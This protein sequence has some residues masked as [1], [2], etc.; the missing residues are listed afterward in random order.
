MDGAESAEMLVFE[1]DGMSEKVQTKLT[2]GIFD[3][4]AQKVAGLI[5]QWIQVMIQSL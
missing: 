3:G 4:E 1:Q 5:W 2:I